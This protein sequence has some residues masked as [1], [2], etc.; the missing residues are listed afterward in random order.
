MYTMTKAWWL[1]NYILFILVNECDGKVCLHDG[2]CQDS[3]GLS[4]W[5]CNCLSG[6]TGK[7]CET[8][9][10]RLNRFIFPWFCGLKVYKRDKVQILQST[11]ILWQEYF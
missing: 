2:T 10:F 1:F 4:T 5:R 3:V 7:L 11:F 9:N 6:F 8:G